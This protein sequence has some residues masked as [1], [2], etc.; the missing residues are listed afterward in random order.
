[1]IEPGE[2]FRV[3]YGNGR[4]VEVVALSMRQKRTVVRSL[5]AI[6]NA[7]DRSQLFD[8]CEEALRV[9]VPDLNDALLDAIDE[10]MAIEI[11]G[12]TVA[13]AALSEDDE[14]K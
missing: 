7:E 2:R 4:S 9:C 13:K 8:A 11:I 12:N 6:Q 14:K 5:E 3:G 1:M 10:Q